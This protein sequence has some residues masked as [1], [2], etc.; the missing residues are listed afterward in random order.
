MVVDPDQ[1]MP[2]L[3]VRSGDV[4]KRLLVV[5]DPARAS[6]ISLL[7]D[8]SREISRNREF[9]LYGGLWKGQEVGVISHGVGSAGAGVCFEELCRSGAQRLIRAGT[10]GGLQSDIVEGSLIVVSGA[11]REEGLTRRL[12]PLSFPALATRDVVTSLLTSAKTY[13]IS[14]HEGLVVTSDLYYP[15]EI[16]ENDLKLWQRAGVKAVEMECSALFIIAALHGV[17]SG[18]IVATDGNPLKNDDVDM[19]FDN[20]RRNKVD[21]AINAMIQ[22]GLD[23][24]IFSV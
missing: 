24:L 4:P 17:E 10:A 12:V 11:V 14:V 23:A 13:G 6:R 2:N 16:L 15:S 20:P 19:S 21:I 18:A 8:K 5:V 3:R 7:L 9:V 22:V 1:M